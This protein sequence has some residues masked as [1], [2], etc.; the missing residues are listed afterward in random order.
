MPIIIS[1]LYFNSIIT[2]FPDSCVFKA[3]KYKVYLITL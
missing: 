2:N 1:G 3:S